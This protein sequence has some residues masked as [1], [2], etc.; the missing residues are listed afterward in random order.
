MALVSTSN[1]E[2]L[3]L[4]LTPPA[5]SLLCDSFSSLATR[6]SSARAMKA[7]LVLN[8]ILSGSLCFSDTQCLTSP[9]LAS[10]LCRDV[11]FK[12][13]LDEG[14]I[15][16]A[17]R[18]RNHTSDISSLIDLVDTFGSTRNKAKHRLLFLECAQFVASRGRSMPW[19]FDSISQ[20]YTRHTLELAEREIGDSETPDGPLPRRALDMLKGLRKDQGIIKRDY[21]YYSIPEK[22]A[23]RGEP[24]TRTQRDFLRKIGSAYY[25]SAIPQSFGLS[26]IYGSQHRAILSL[27][28]GTSLRPKKEDDISLVPARVR[29]DHLVEGLA[30]LEPDDVETLR[31]FATTYR[32]RFARF[33]YFPDQENLFALRESAAELHGRI[34]DAILDRHPQW[35]SEA[36]PDSMRKIRSRL[37]G[38]SIGAE[39]AI[40]VGSLLMS[41]ALPFL[42][43]VVDVIF[44][45]TK[46]RLAGDKRFAANAAAR[47]AASLQAAEDHLARIGKSAKLRMETDVELGASKVEIVDLAFLAN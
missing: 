23:E 12:R 47:Q 17:V 38:A 18:N 44:R 10:L 8:Y 41:H 6:P 26:P 40:E 31:R 9:N 5:F 1:A 20:Y 27:R 24:L 7:H 28:T 2:E 11:L 33:R 34:D 4:D 30:G 42:G 39:T 13:L 43:L 45:V 29:A 32:E 15:T 3:A 16:V 19:D 25:F 46:G 22:L 36:S 37:E 14:E 21:L 35:S